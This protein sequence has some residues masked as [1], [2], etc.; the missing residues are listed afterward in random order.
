MA[1]SVATP[2]AGV[3]EPGRRPRL[4]MFAVSVLILI[5]GAMIAILTWQRAVEAG[6]VGADLQ[7]Y[8]H[9]ASQF[10]EGGGFYPAHQLAGPYV[11]ADGDIL[12]PPPILL[13][14]VPFLVLPG[15]FFWV[16]PL[17]V[18][19]A[20]VARH[21]PG[22]WSWPLLALTLSYPVTSLKIVH[23]NP[24]MWVAAA[25]ALA[26]ITAGPAVLVLV[27][28]TLAPF[29]LIGAN[30]RRWWITLAAFGVVAALFAPMWPDYLK[31]AMNA[32]SQ[33]GLL[34][35]L[36]EVPLMLIPIIAWIASP[37]VT[38]PGRRPN[39]RS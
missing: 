15:I 31:V 26:T 13:L 9:S 2:A 29:A 22:P 36:D 10:L 25:V 32:Q 11:V 28:P 21:R 7:L 37:G 16:V 30:R 8:L 12:Y 1:E 27:K 24:V 4:L 35:S 38:I 6:R 19:A 39:L 3:V 20:V 23:G 18:I 34:Y 5:G 17:G 14:I 33:N